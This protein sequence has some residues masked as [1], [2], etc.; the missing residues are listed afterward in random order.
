MNVLFGLTMHWHNLYAPSSL[1]SDRELLPK[2]EF[3]NSK[4]STKA[5]RQLQGD[6]STSNLFCFKTYFNFNGIRLIIIYNLCGLD[7]LMIMTGELPP[8]LNELA[9][10]CPFVFA[11]ETRQLL[12][13]IVSFDRD[14][15][16]Q[17][18]YDTGA[19]PDTTTPSSSAP[20]SSM[21]SDANQRFVPKIEKKK[22]C[23]MCWTCNFCCV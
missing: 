16:M 2:T 11:F 7:P 15:A 8:W 9:H 17:Y 13:R 22:V 12:F 5:H 1:R 4:L 18:L 10:S 21:A 20:S 6:Y 14:R 3:V 23:M 19:L